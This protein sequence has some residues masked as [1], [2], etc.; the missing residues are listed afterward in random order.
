MGLAIFYSFIEG[1]VGDHGPLSRPPAI[2]RADK[3]KG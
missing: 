1:K 3:G 2:L